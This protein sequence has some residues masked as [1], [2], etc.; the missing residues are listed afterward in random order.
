VV[1]D[2]HI[3]STLHSTV[4]CRL[5]SILL[6]LGV[7]L[8]F[9]PLTIGAVVV[10]K[11]GSLVA[12]GYLARVPKAIRT[13]REEQQ[14]TEAE[15]EAFERFAKAVGDLDLITEQNQTDATALY[16]VPAVRSESPTKTMEAVRTLYRE[17]VMGVDHYQEEYDESLSENVAAEFGPE[18]TTAMTTNDNINPILQQAFVTRSRSAVQ[19]R[20]WFQSVINGEIE[21]LSTA[22][23]QL[24]DIS[25]V[26]T[27]TREPDPN[28]R[29]LLEVHDAVQRLEDAEAECESL[30]RSRHDDYVD[31]PR[32]ENLHLQEY[33]YHQ[34]EW[35]HPVIGDALDTVRRIRDTKREIIIAVFDDR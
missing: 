2:S 19:E 6:I 9:T 32:Q 14:R 24:R 5:A 33:L 26:T 16:R 12:A 20:A 35:T 27:R 4:V 1:L 25:R 7:I 10:P 3:K 11:S 21:A 28:T 23:T 17:T 34:Y 8:R 18:L 29:S 15:G 13:A 31:A 30:I 22:E